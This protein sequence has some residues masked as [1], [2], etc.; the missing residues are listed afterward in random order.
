MAKGVYLEELDATTRPCKI[1]KTGEN[2]FNIILTQGLN[3]QIRRMT[4]A[5]GAKVTALHRIRIMNI[6]IGSLK[7]GEI[8]ELS[9]EEL[10]ELYKL[11]GYSEK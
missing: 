8:R 10:K 5:C 3:R 11:T 2:T 1:K 7:S 9:D 6:K 4:E